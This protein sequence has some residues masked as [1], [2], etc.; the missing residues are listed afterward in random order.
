MRDGDAVADMQDSDGDDGGDVEPDRDVD[1]LSR[2][3]A[4]VPKK[5]TAKVTHSSAMTMSST[6]GSSAYS[7][8]C[9]VTGDQG[10]CRRDDDATASR[11]VNLRQRVTQHARLQQT[12]Y[13]VV[14]AG[15][16]MLPQNAKMTAL[17]CGGRRPKV[18]NGTMFSP[19]MNSIAAI[20]TPTS[21]PTT[22]RP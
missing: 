16:I 18:R 9:V 19:G 2:R 1:V 8:P 12:L 10:E 3:I 11:K 5:L 15:K 13:R 21:M 22:A 20:K 14:D 4:M 17:V 7:L 6:H